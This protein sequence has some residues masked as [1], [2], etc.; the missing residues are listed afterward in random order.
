MGDRADRW[1]PVRV[2][3][4]E[5]FGQSRVLMVDCG[6]NHSAVV[7]EEGGLWAWGCGEHGRL[8][9]GD[10]EDRLMPVRVEAERLDGA[11]IVSAACGAAHTAAV[12]EEGA[13]YTWGKGEAYAGSQVPNGLGHD[14]LED[15]LLP[16]LV[17]PLQQLGARVGRCLPLPRLHAL[18]FAMGTHR[19]L[20]AGAA[21]AGGGGR[22]MS[23]RVQGKEPD[24][25]RRC[26]YGDM[27]EDLVRR[28]VEACRGWPEGAA[29]KAEGVVRLVGGGSGKKE[30]REE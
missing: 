14:D 15:K 29:G 28:V 27:P 8:G 9:H 19:R 11:K 24:E 30:G 12:T 26:A 10:E 23:R 20:G 25:G 21:G 2:G 3:A 17:A 22:R 6:A 4:E 7:T 5:A 13:L 1:A 16:T 18:A